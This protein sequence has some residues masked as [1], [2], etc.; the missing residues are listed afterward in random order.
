MSRIYSH[1]YITRRDVLAS[2][3]NVFSL[4]YSRVYLAMVAILNAIVWW[5]SIYI[6]QHI[7]GDLLILH[8]NVDFGIN[9][10]GDPKR[11]FIFPSLVLFLSLLNVFLLL[12]FHKDR[13]LK[14]MVHLFLSSAVLINIFML[15][16]L[17]SIYLINFR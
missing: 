5:G 1:I 2:L 12:F 11:I 10:I 3:I 4:L 17:M 14:F 13:Y 8:Y 16:A 6:Y 15:V 9:L 7:S